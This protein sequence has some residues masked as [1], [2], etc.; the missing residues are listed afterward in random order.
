M[1]SLLRTSA[2]TWVAYGE[3]AA[4][5]RLDRWTFAINDNGDVLIRGQPLP[6][7]PGDRL[8]EVEG[9]VVPAGWTWSPALA[10]SVLRQVCGL[11]TGELALLHPDGGWE[12]VSAS[13]FVRASHSAIRQT[14]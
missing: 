5:V 7:I 11:E 4:Q 3:T 8:V 12:R 6:P 2:A 1:A 10:A 9:I 14:V 13:C